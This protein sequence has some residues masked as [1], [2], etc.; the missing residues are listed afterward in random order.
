MGSAAC[1]LIGIPSIGTIGLV[2]NST[3]LLHFH[4]D[5]SAIHGVEIVNLLVGVDKLP[6]AP[7]EETES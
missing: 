7:V 5:S 6:K 1:L 2:L 4:H 3:P